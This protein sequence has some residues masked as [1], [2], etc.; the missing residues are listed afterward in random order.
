MVQ[1][2]KYK[3]QGLQDQQICVRPGKR[4]KKKS[5]VLERKKLYLGESLVK[6]VIEGRVQGKKEIGGHMSCY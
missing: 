5:F 3:L 4:K 6:E 2:R 1:Y